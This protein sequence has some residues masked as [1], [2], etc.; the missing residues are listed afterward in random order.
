[1][2]RGTRLAPRVC[3]PG[4]AGKA[5]SMIESLVAVRGLARVLVA[6]HGTALALAMSWGCS[7]ESD[8]QADAAEAAEA[9]DSEAARRR[10]YRGGAGGTSGSGGMTSNAGKAATGGTT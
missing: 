9:S 1:M 4:S 8:G 2:R 5:Q 10:P 6:G 7:A 3:R